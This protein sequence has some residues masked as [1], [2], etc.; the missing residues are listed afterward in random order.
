M[1][2]ISHSALQSS[3]ILMVKNKYLLDWIKWENIEHQ[4]ADD[5]FFLNGK[6]IDEWYLIQLSRD[7][8]TQVPAE[9]MPT[10][11]TW[12]LPREP[13]EAQKLEEKE[14]LKLR[15]DVELDIELGWKS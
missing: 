3:P 8:E 10:R 1:H 14:T 5:I 9:E 13:W 11:C 12:R 15:W 4:K 7:V 2:L 6:G